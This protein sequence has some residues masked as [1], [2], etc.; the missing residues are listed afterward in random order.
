MN[1]KN[2][3]LDLICMNPFKAW[4][5]RIHDLFFKFSKKTQNLYLDLK[6]CT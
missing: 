2:P 3:D 4:I 6:L 5:V 1:L